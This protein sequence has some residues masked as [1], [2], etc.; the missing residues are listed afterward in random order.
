MTN[1]A[2]RSDLTDEAL[3]ALYQTALDAVLNRGG[4]LNEQ[5][6]PDAASSA[7]ERLV[8]EVEGGHVIKDREAHVKRAA[9]NWVDAPL[10]LTIDD[11]ERLHQAALTGARSVGGRL[12]SLVAEDAANTALAKM[13]TRIY[14]GV[15]IKNLAAYVS[16]A[17]RNWTRNYIEAINKLPPVDFDDIPHGAQVLSNLQNMDP[18]VVVVAKE[19]LKLREL[20]FRCTVSLLD[21]RDADILRALRSDEQLPVAQLA[22]TFEFH[23]DAF[24]RHRYLIERVSHYAYDSLMHPK[25]M[26]EPRRYFAYCLERRV[27]EPDSGIETLIDQALEWLRSHFS[28]KPTAY[29]ETT[30]SM[31]LTAWRNNRPGPGRPSI[32]AKARRRLLAAAAEYVLLEEDARPDEEQDGFRDDYEVVRS[33]RRALGMDAPNSG[34]TFYSLSG[35]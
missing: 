23:P 12:A 2:V 5:L 31:L 33:V 18:G 8:E 9:Q 6:A 30:H 34:H 1:E 32:N 3:E 7:I 4:Q 22:A 26:S 29:P 25:L 13:V 10:N 27:D 35:E 21:T 19:M 28:D 11:L 20:V 16:T 17:A 14:D 24:T 15:E